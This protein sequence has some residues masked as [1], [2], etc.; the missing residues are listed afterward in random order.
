MSGYGFISAFAARLD[1][2]VEFKA[3]MGFYGA[4]RIWYLRRFDAYCAGHG[5]TV[6]D[7][8]T[9]EGWV[10]AQLSTSGRYRSWM[11][12]IRDFGRWLTVHGDRDA[13]VLS[14]EW[15]ARFVPA[16]PYL[17]TTGEIEAFFDAAARLDTTSPWRW[18]AVAFFTLMHSCGLRTCEAR[19]LLA[20]HVD[21]PGRHLQ[22][23][24]SKGRR[25]RRLPITRDVADVLAASDTASTVRLGGSRKTFFTSSTGNPVTL[26]TVGVIFNR[27]WDTAGLPRQAGSK[28]P[29]PYD[30]R[31]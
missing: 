22:V 19:S 4:S 8:D 20:E 31:H 27:I 1:E 15:K 28:R 17:L 6:F 26:A 23:V 2:Y 5:L 24:W 29:R 11:S 10:T 21:L 9:V 14:D 16:N 13:Y 12:Y 25:S 7:R 18:Q 3:S 30:F